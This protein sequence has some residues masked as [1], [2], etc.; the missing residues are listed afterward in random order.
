MRPATLSKKTLAQVFSCEFC[1]I[2]KKK[3]FY[4]TPPV[5]ASEKIAIYKTCFHSP[6][7]HLSG[8][9]SNV[10]TK[11][12]PKHLPKFPIQAVAILISMLSCFH[13]LKHDGWINWKD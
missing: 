6:W 12:K 2:S 9:Y 11:I 4:R 1:E 13:K 10:I 5:A 3:F 8:E 7:V